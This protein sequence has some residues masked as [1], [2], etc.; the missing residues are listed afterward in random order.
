[1]FRPA[2][3]PPRRNSNKT[4]IFY[5]ARVSKKHFGIKSFSDLLVILVIFFIIILNYLEYFRQSDASLENTFYRAL[6]CGIGSKLK[7]LEPQH[8]Y[9]LLSKFSY[10]KPDLHS[11]LLFTLKL[12]FFIR[13]VIIC[14][15]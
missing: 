3:F 13:N 1:M 7:T 5:L 4:L 2:I 14:N 8:Y 10:K 9:H 6:T 11:S 15:V 12:L